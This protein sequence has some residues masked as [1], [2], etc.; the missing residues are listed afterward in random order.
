MIHPHCV[1]KLVYIIQYTVI[2]SL[3][4]TVGSMSVPEM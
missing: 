2:H 1:I 4:I 3:I